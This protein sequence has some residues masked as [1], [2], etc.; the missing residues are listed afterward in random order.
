MKENNSENRLNYKRYDDVRRPDKAR[1]REDYIGLSK[2]AKMNDNSESRNTYVNHEVDKP[3]R[4][5][6]SND[7]LGPL[8]GKMNENDSETRLNYKSYDGVKRPN[9]ARPKQD[10][11]GLPDGRID[12]ETEN[13]YTYKGHLPLSKPERQGRIGDNLSPMKNEKMIE[14]TQHKQTYTHHTV[15]K[16]E[17]IRQGNNNI[18][19]S[20]VNMDTN[21]E[22]RDIYKSHDTEKPIRAT[23]NGDMLSKF[24]GE[25]QGDSE[26]KHNY[27]GYDGFGKPERYRVADHLAPSSS[28]LDDRTEAKDSYDPK[29]VQR[30]Q[31]VRGTNDTMGIPEGRF[32]QDTESRNKYLSHSSVVTRPNKPERTTNF[33]LGEGAKLEGK[34]EMHGQYSAKYGR[35]SDQIK[36]REN[37][38]AQRSKSMASLSSITSHDYRAGFDSRRPEK[39]SMYYSHQIS[40]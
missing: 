19:L 25:F 37:L 24:E 7:T 20:K 32:E 23:N 26:F 31:R 17:R 8:E 1:S 2:D 28:R 14:D 38:S 35:R 13:K 18:A 15:E 3:E 5:T 33:S 27:K 40:S 4:I 16:I 34:S 22:N 36:P 10:V 11:V 6:K 30:L 9:R 21:T 12:D 29:E 39:V